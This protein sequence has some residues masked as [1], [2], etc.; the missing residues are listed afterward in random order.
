MA[1]PIKFEITEDLGKHW[2][3]NGNIALAIESN[4]IFKY[5]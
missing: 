2:K 3:I 4:S 1:K 5:F